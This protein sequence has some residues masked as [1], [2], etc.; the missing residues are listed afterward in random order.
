MLA[1]DLNQGKSQYFLVDGAVLYNTNEI[2]LG[3]F[4]AFNGMMSY[5]KG[6][7]DKIISPY[8]RDFI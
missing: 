8:K 7:D 1:C 6:V 5:Y 4:I 3:V 2:H